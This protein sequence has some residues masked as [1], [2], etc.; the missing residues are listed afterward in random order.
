MRVFLDA[1]VLFSASNR[2]SNIA[3]L[4]AL[5]AKDWEAVTSDIACVEARKNLVLERPD[6]LSAFE[7]LLGRVEIVPSASFDLG[8]E[9]DRQDVPLL[10]AAIRSKCRYFATGDRRDF[11]HLF[12]KA[13]HG[14]EVITLL[15][16]AVLLEEDQVG[17]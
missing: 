12:G 2:S 5:V 15:R 13:V 14:V 4:V 8:V 7:K 9:L 1:N 16:L 6:W 10:C 17:E 3:R 11:G